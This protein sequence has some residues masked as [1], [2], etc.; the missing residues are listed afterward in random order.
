MDSVSDALEGLIPKFS[1]Q[2]ALLLLLAL[3]SWEQILRPGGVEGSSGNT[4]G[5]GCSPEWDGAGVAGLSPCW[6]CLIY[7]VL[8]KW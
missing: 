4:P 7:T 6:T 2:R 1:L 3:L 5:P 8:S